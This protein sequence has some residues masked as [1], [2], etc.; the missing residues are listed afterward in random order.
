MRTYLALLF[1]LK[2]LFINFY[3]YSKD[4][5]CLY[6]INELKINQLQILGS[7]N[8]YH[9]RANKFVLRF[10]KG[11]SGILPKEINPK[12]LDYAHEPLTVQLDSFHL[13]SV[14]IDIYADPQGGHYYSRKKNNLL[15]KPKASGIEELKQPGF[16]VMHIPDIDYNT[17][18]YTFKS[19][20]T[21]LKIWSD[22]HPSHLPIYVLIECK[23]ETIADK[24]SKLHFTKAIPFSV[25]IMNDVDKEIKSVF[26]DSLQKIITPDRVRDTFA[27]LR[28][29]VLAGNF[30]TLESARGKF[31]FVMMEVGAENY[32][33]NHPSLKGRV[34]FNFSTPDKPECAF[35]KYDDAIKNETAI[36][37]AVQKG[38]IVRTRADEPNH[39]NRSGDYA[40]QQAAFRSGA[41]I[42]S[43]DYYTPDV[44]YK[45]H[46]K[47]FKNFFTKFQGNDIA[48]VN[49]I[50]MPKL[51]INE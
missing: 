48:R 35:I 9:K 13:R 40:Q 18:N 34:M 32:L 12:E 42:I 2:L 25:E 8:S 22:A 14:E 16:K 5:S 27:T 24:I 31:I 51:K 7:H 21:E 11:L 50:A 38:F 47:K 36:T 33:L 10:L 49:T 26:G 23:E 41:Q 17:N 39:Q 3:S 43:S 6:N 1:V 29:A 46:P 45:K 44:R 28:D 4:D 37:D 15:G 30:P 19:A 20:L